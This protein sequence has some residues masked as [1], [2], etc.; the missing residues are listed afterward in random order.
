MKRLILFLFILFSAL[1]ATLKAQCVVCPCFTVSQNRGCAPL[2]ISVDGSC[3]AG[4]ASQLLYNYDYSNDPTNFVTA[5]THQ[6][7][8][9]GNYVV[10]QNANDPVTHNHYYKYDTIEVLGQPLPKYKT[11]LC[12]NYKVKI[13]ITD[14]VY[15]QFHVD[16]GDGTSI[17]MGSNASYICTYLN[18]NPRTITVTGSYL[19]SGGIILC[20]SAPVT[21]NLVPFLT[22][23]APDMIDLTVN[24]QSTTTGSISFRY[25]GIANRLYTIE[26][27]SPTVIDTINS[28]STGIVTQ[29][30]NALNTQATIYTIRMK[31]IDMC[32]TLPH[33]SSDSISSIIVN[34]SA[35]NGSNQVTFSSNA[36]LSPT[37]TLNRDATLLQAAATSPYTDNAVTCEK[38][39]CYQVQA[40][41]PTTSVTSGTFHKSYSVSSCVKAVY[42]AAAPAVTN[43]NSTVD[44][45]QVKLVW[46]LP[47][48]N[49]IVPSVD[50]YTVY[51]NNNGTYANYG[52]SNSN[53]YTDNG[54][55]VNASAYCYQI[56]YKDHCNNVSPL[57]NITCDVNLI[58]TRTDET[59][60]LTWTSYTGYQSGI[61]EYIIENLDEN[62]NVVV[63]KSA[64]LSTSFSEATDPS[65]SQLIYR[66]RVVS[67]GS[68]NI[69]SYSNIQ[70]I[71]LT[72]QIY[73]P[74][75]FTPNGDGDN[76]VLEVKGKYYKSVKMTILN[77]WGEVLFISDN[78]AQGWDGNYKGQPVSV[79]S[80]AYHVVA[81]DNSGK[82]ISLKGVVSLIR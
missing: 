55:N 70:R 12:A 26:Y 35:S 76:D 82:E 60:N 46:D 79:D 61:K 41:L 34:S 63:S 23:V 10:A 4:P 54:A 78:T 22:L 11:D 72:P 6:Y 14:T 1:P 67:V 42:T 71:D 21:T 17:N 31:N 37:Y 2:T 20:S 19:N 36:G 65:L 13:S 39:Y 16:L 25:S 48:L 64:G 57:S 45:N 49:P 27:G 7:T 50:Y 52:S 3:Y 47:V 53:S 18:S 24:N 43:V 5:T 15:D 28:T 80:Y 58:A 75:V 38:T 56:S 69:V 66:I 33:P 62:G 32:N 77:K 51:R 9:P 8:I 68:E 81:F 73:M 29:T 40:T 74:N 44:G 59:N 30:I